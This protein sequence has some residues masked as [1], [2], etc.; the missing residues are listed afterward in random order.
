M[1]A[2]IR[3]LFLMCFLKS[4]IQ[5]HILSNSCLIE[6]NK[7]YTSKCIQ[8]YTSKNAWPTVPCWISQELES[9]SYCGMK[10]CFYT[11]IC[12]NICSWSL[13]KCCFRSMWGCVLFCPVLLIKVAIHVLSIMLDFTFI[14]NWNISNINQRFFEE[15]LHK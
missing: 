12:H 9:C 11:K 6:S 14:C 4:S 8:M 3:L 5:I 10:K 2:K 15:Q 7:Y 1:S 13:R